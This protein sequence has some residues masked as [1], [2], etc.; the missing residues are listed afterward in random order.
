[1][2]LTETEWRKNQLAINQAKKQ[3]N[4]TQSGESN[5]TSVNP[6]ERP[7]ANLNNLHSSNSN[8]NS[9]IN[10]SLPRVAATIK[11]P[12]ST[13][14]FTASPSA[15]SKNSSSI[16]NNKNDLLGFD[17]DF[18]LNTS[19]VSNQSLFKSSAN[20]YSSSITN[21]AQNININVTTANNKSSL[22]LPAPN[23]RKS[24]RRSASQ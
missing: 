3:A 19:P 11:P 8:L 4:S 21:S 15:N 20:P 6:R 18:N 13:S 23:E 5:F 2:P 22:L 7:K 1:M 24:H 17:D 14:P 16:N 10:I 9:S 12:V